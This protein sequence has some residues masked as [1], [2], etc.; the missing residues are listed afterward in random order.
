MQK[1]RLNNSHHFLAFQNTYE[2][3]EIGIFS[4]ALMLEGH[5]IIAKTAASKD[6]IP[7]LAS[8]LGEHKYILTD[9]PF[10]VVNQGPGPFTT[11]RVVISTVNGLSFATGI[12]LM[13]VDA[14]EAAHREWEDD[15]YPITAIM[16]N[17]FAFDVYVAIAKQGTIVFKGSANIDQLLEKLKEEHAPIR[18]IGNGATLYREK[19]K[20]ILG[21][22]AVIPEV[23]LD[24][25]SL[26]SIA[27]LGHAQ[28]QR[29][30]RG[31]NQLLPLYLK[32]YSAHIK[33]SQ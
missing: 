11:L 16:F 10:I 8:F 18:C 32:Q 13:G 26:T 2:Q 9:F 3:V 21:N 22:K 31:V 25:C 24:Y 1:S 6:V 4:S 33:N 15:A 20:T 19:I 12:P 5:C 7:T 27:Q 29:G 23:N 14:L 28:W 30:E 17:A